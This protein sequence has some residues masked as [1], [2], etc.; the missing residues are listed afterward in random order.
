MIITCKKPMKYMY[1][2]NPHN[3]KYI[4]D[5]EGWVLPNDPEINASQQLCENGIVESY[6]SLDY[7]YQTYSF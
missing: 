2:H 7:L 4:F 5:S 1:V 3:R 6:V